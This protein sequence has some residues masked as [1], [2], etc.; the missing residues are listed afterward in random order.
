MVAPEVEPEDEPIYDA[1]SGD[2]AED[3][4]EYVEEEP[5]EEE[6]PIEST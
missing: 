2:K 5:T 6:S 4:I 3:H 1:P